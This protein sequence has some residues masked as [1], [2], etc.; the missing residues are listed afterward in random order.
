MMNVPDIAQ[1]KN[2]IDSFWHYAE[3]THTYG[4]DHSRN[5]YKRC[6]FDMEFGK[7][8]FRRRRIYKDP[9]TGEVRETIEIDR[10]SIR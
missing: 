10:T 7:G 8:K 6:Q 1:R 5:K 3:V 4:R 9:R 2:E